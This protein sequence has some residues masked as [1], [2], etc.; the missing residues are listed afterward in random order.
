VRS[1]ITNRWGQVPVE[2][3]GTDH[4]IVFRGYV[5]GG[6]NHHHQITS[7]NGR[8]YVSWSD[9]VVH[10]DG[11]GQR[12]LM[13]TSDD[14]GE[15]WSQASVVVGRLPGRVGMGVVTGMGIHIH[16]G[17]M[18]AYYGYYDYD[19]R[20]VQTHLERGNYP[21]QELD[22]RVNYDTHTG[23]MVSNDE[24]ATW[25]GPVA[26]IDRFVPN[27]C[28]QR[29]RS[30]RLIMPGNMWYPYTDDP[31][32]IDGWTIAGIPRLPEGHCDDPEGFWY[33][34]AARGDAF[35]V[36]EGSCYET[37]DGV[38][39]MMLRCE[40]GLGWL[41]VTESRDL[42]E[43]WSEPVLTEF[44]DAN[45]RFHFGRLP[46]GRFFAVSCPEPGSPRTPLI[47]AV[48][49]DGVVFDR[50]FLLGDEPDAPPRLEGHHKGG[51]YGYP[52]YHILGDTLFVAYSISKED[53]AVCRL[54]IRDLR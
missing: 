4:F 18:A 15:T 1:P 31:Y 17:R 28:P 49:E 38:V 11:P 36:C 14:G 45:C 29:L 33:S 3:I 51:R 12:M 23:I 6:Y 41:A 54:N 44:T 10:E 13:A 43:T 40:G 37:D 47:L 8:L 35:I 48:S 53:I 25:E 39:H 22:F 7:L 20:G 42:G 19:E 50:H 26:K 24:G 52:S 9:G 32:G 2:R 21:K 30:G 5:S 27:L 46:D 34:K 16:E